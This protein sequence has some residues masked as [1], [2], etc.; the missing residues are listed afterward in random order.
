MSLRKTLELTGSDAA[1][2][3]VTCTPA[4][5]NLD[6]YRVV[7]LGGS[8]V[9]F[10]LSAGPF[11]H[12]WT[13]AQNPTTIEIEPV[14]DLAGGSFSGDTLTITYDFDASLVSV[15]PLSHGQEAWTPDAYGNDQPAYLVGGATIAGGVLLT[16][17]G[18]GALVTVSGNLTSAAQDWTIQGEHKRTGA[19]VGDRVFEWSQ[20]VN[21]LVQ[22]YV[23]GG[24]RIDAWI[25][26]GG[27]FT[28]INGTSVAPVGSFIDWALSYDHSTN[29]LRLMVGGAAVVTAVVDLSALTGM[30]FVSIGY[31]HSDP[32]GSGQAGEAKDVRILLGQTAT[33][34]PATSTPLPLA[35]QAADENSFQWDCSVARTM[36]DTGADE[37]ADTLDYLAEQ[38]QD[39]NFLKPDSDQGG[40]DDADDP[41]PLDDL[42]ESSWAQDWYDRAGGTAAAALYATR[43]ADDTTPV[44]R[45]EHTNV[46][47]G[48]GVNTGTA[49]T[50]TADGA[51]VPDIAGLDFRV[52]WDA[53]GS[54]GNGMVASTPDAG[55]SRSHFVVHARGAGAGDV[56][57]WESRTAAL[58]A[59]RNRVLHS[60]TGFDIYSGSTLRSTITWANVADQPLYLATLQDSGNGL[61]FMATELGSRFANLGAKGGNIDGADVSSQ[62]AYRNWGGNPVAAVTSRAWAFGVS[63]QQVQIS[64][65]VRN[66]HAMMG[67]NPEVFKDFSG[68][69]R[70]AIV[71]GDVTVN[72]TPAADTGAHGFMVIPWDAGLFPNDIRIKL[73]YT[74]NNT[75][76]A[77][78]R[79]LI[80][81]NSRAFPAGVIDLRVLPG[82]A[83]NLDYRDGAVWKTLAFDTGVTG[84][85]EVEIEIRLTAG[86][87]TAYLDTVLQTNTMAV[88]HADPG[89]DM[90]I[91]AVLHST[92]G[93]PALG[94][95]RD[96]E[97]RSGASTVLADLPMSAIS[98]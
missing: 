59:N 28:T 27:V 3:D 52:D 23:D 73:K 18:Q 12:S 35:P 84:G 68:N 10:L 64:D 88:T 21:N 24:G 34:Q 32:K 70:D 66:Y 4:G 87:W 89:L 98:T 93:Q 90:L 43:L 82:G 44:M 7:G 50:R 49:T 72:G 5:S 56:A 48:Q 33:S 60:A 15:V 36:V 39:T 76:E 42:V 62:P 57:V 92:T 86:T 2:Y 45:A 80:Y 65:F 20:D 37:D 61:S 22:I 54:A 25:G 14:E 19:T 16:D 74:P 29:T 17:D 96:L 6:K 55:N 51:T 53:S 67:T 58:T 47:V 97:I 81:Q 11:G 30:Q 9:S 95:I 40:V 8:P 85:V 1:S 46:A 75:A 94:A 71:C 69:G 79:N 91:G 26:V 63:S 38:A 31:G 78:V 83:I 77:A 41:D 13:S